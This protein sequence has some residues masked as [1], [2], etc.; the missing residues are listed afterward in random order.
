MAA[1]SRFSPYVV[2][3]D[4][5]SIQ[6]T[7]GEAIDSEWH[8]GLAKDSVMNVMNR[9]LQKLDRLPILVKVPAFA[10]A[11]LCAIPLGCFAG[12]VGTVILGSL[13]FGVVAL[14]IAERW[15]HSLL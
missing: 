15:F 8:L 12:L 6:G 14:I 11:V 4:T 9:I 2:G 5:S 10:F 7:A 13:F 1:N 3:G